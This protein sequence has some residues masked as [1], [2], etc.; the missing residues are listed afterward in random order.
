MS[1]VAIGVLAEMRHNARKALSHA[2][3]GGADWH[4]DELIV[5]AVA[6]RVR[7]VA[8]LA[9]YRFPAEEKEDYPEITWDALARARDF[10]THHYSRLD[11][12]QLRETVDAALPALIE[13]VDALHLPE[14]TEEEPTPP[15]A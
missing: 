15:G 13:A 11:P 8:E 3:R 4:H 6:S 12:Q 2:A 5:D 14:L 10:Y 9:K 7:Q 1:D